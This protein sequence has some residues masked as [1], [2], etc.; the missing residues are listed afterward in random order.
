[1][2]TLKSFLEN[3]T[4]ITFGD[5]LTHGMYIDKIGGPHKHHPYSIELEKILRKNDINT[6][7]IESGVNGERSSSM[8]HRIKRVLNNPLIHDFNHTIQNYKRIV[9]IMAGTNDLHHGG[10]EHQILQDVIKLHKISHISGRKENFNVF[11][12]LLTIPQVGYFDT[13][14]ELKRIRIN[15]EL[16]MYSL[17]CSHVVELQEMDQYL[18]IK[19][20][21]NNIF[22]CPD[23]LHFTPTGYDKIGNIVYEALSR[24]ANKVQ[25]INSTNIMC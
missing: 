3:S 6:I 21:N 14:N 19:N 23:N 5:S 4:I 12:I 18:D 8:V 9:V 24:L 20:S 10:S 17:N 22:W 7:V 16:K 1:M 15:D 11:T 13:N 2:V 25:Q